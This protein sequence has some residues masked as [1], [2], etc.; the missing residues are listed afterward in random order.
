MGTHHKILEGTW[1]KCSIL[2]D[3]FEGEFRRDCSPM[4][5]GSLD[6][7]LTLSQA[8]GPRDLGDIVGSLVEKNRHGG[9]P[10]VLYLMVTQMDKE[11]ID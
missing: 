1:W 5:L 7:Y 4:L 2:D 3:I 11:W 9:D 10:M 8:H 6:V